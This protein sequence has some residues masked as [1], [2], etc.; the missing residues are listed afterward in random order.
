MPRLA[1]ISIIN[2]TSPLPRWRLRFTSHPTLSRRVF[3]YYHHLR[4][5]EMARIAYCAPPSCCETMDDGSRSSCSIEPRRNPG[6]VGAQP[7]VIFRRGTSGCVLFVL[8]HLVTNETNPSSEALLSLRG[9]GP[10]D[11]G[12]G[13]S[14]ELLLYGALH[15]NIVPKITKTCPHGQVTQHS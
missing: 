11:R 4:A 5:G 9:I 12:Y 10:S 7:G 3:Y 14:A 13:P 2:T 15:A 6:L 8:T 1:P